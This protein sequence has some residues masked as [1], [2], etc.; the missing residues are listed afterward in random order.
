MTSPQSRMN[1]HQ[2]QADN[3][4]RMRLVGCWIAALTVASGTVLIGHMILTL[5]VALPDIIAR[6][7]ALSAM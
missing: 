4:S 6:G 5:A 2:M 1:A 3:M 7:A